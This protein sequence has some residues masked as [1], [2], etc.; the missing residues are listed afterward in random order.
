[1]WGRHHRQPVPLVQMIPDPENLEAIAHEQAT[2]LLAKY[3]DGTYGPPLDDDMRRLFRKFFVLGFL[4]ASK[5]VDW[6]D[7][8]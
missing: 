7:G 2:A 8:L 5:R 3:E 6:K 1:M 4:S